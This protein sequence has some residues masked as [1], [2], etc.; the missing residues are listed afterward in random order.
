M[1]IGYSERLINEDLLVKK[2][3]K[4]DKKISIFIV[5]FYYS[6][7]L[8][9]IIKILLPIP[10]SL[11]QTIS[12]TFTLFLLIIMLLTIF[13]VLKRSLSP[14]ILTENLFIILF[15]VSFLQG[16]ADNALLMNNAFWT[17]G[18][19]IPLA[20]YVY[21]V[22]NLNI[23]YEV[24]YKSSY[25]LAI[26]LIFALFKMPSTSGKLY[27]MSLSYS[28]VIPM[29]FLING[30]F[31]SKKVSALVISV[32][33]IISIAFYGARGPLLCIA[34]FVFMKCFCGRIKKVKNLIIFMIFILLVF[35]SI[36]YFNPI[37]NLFAV[38]LEKCG[39]YSRTIRMILKGAILRGSGRDVLFNHYW[40]L[41][42]E[43]PLFGWGLLGGWVKEGSGPHNM[44]LEYLLA[45]GM[46]L[47]CILCFWFIALLFKPLFAKEKILKELLMIFSAANITMYFVS[48]SFLKSY[49]WF[50]FV[51]LCMIKKKHNNSNKLIK[52]LM[53]GLLANE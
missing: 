50:I 44:L 8:N 49:N 34:F 14:F 31:E 23:F 30:F 10:D 24:L 48:G 37:V 52:M 16:N 33:G 29:L 1:E 46:I 35:I 21:S 6:Q 53:E 41:I 42:Q 2:D 18:V 9:S 22:Q 5:T 4:I 51:A 7:A 32:A 36:L 38:F 20:I 3:S 13:P 47:G 26:M 40:G 25:V 27:N 45:F 39:I 17:L 15:L 12:N 11:W 43:K 28:L 19:C